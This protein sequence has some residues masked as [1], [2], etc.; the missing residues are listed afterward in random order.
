MIPPTFSEMRHDVLEREFNQFIIELPEEQ[1]IVVSTN[2]SSQSPI[3]E[4]DYK[5]MVEIVHQI[6][7]GQITV[8]I[9]SV[10]RGSQSLV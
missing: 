4:V 2:E 1:N 6:R 7:I 5:V 10:E 3:D 8:V 9:I